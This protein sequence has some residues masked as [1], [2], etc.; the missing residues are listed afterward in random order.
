MAGQR[1]W[2]VR[3]RALAALRRRLRTIVGK[4]RNWHES[5]SRIFLAHVGEA[6][7]GVSRRRRLDLHRDLHGE[8][9]RRRPVPRALQGD[10]LAWVRHDCD[11]NVVLISYDAT[12]WIEVD[13][14]WAGNVDLDPGVSVAVG[15]IFVVVVG[16]MHVSGHEARGNSAR[17]QC[18]DHQHSEVATTPAAEIKGADWILNSLLVSR[19]V[20]EGPPDGPCHVDEQFVRV[21]GSVSAE[22]DCA[23]AIEFAARGGRQ[24]ETFETGPIFRRV[25]KRI[26]AG[27]ILD[28]GCVKAGR[29]MVETNLA[30]KTKL[31]G[32][33]GEL[34]SRN[35]IAETV[36]R[37]GLGLGVIS[38]SVSITF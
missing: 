38:S 33:F 3:S 23:P 1:G 16:Q 17:A 25:G 36:L 15:N 20:L 7:P 34:G 30:D 9:I 24:N 37:P 11:A 32:A 35:M 19:Y 26:R 10:R 18:R 6:L 4:S 28:I 2:E 31:G 21:G 8:M 29:R 13:P 14:A 12:G 27:K 5:S 22:E